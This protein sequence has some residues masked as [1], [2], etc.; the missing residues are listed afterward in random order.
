MLRTP[1]GRHP[2]R[3][4]FFNQPKPSSPPLSGRRLFLRTDSW[5]CHQRVAPG[6]MKVDRIVRRGTRRCGHGGSQGLAGYHEPCAADRAVSRPWPGLVLLKGVA[7]YPFQPSDVGRLVCSD[8]LAAREGL[9]VP[10]RA[11]RAGPLAEKETHALGAMRMIVQKLHHRVLEAH[12][13]LCLRVAISM[14]PDGDA[15]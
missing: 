3:K 7:F 15:M 8:C 14:T 11:L 10:F 4:P 6:P 1:R 9:V 13:S 5:R 12:S 2:S